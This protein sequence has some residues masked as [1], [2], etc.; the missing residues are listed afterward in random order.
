L[1]ALTLAALSCLALDACGGGSSSGDSAASN[2]A[3]P[4]G[5]SGSSGGTGSPGGGGTTPVSNG[6]LALATNTYTVAETTGTVSVTV[7]RSGGSDGAVTVQYATADGT[8]AAGSNYTAGTGT[9]SWAASD[10]SAKTVSIPVSSNPAFSGTKTFT[11]TLSSVAGGAALGTPMAA[12]VSI[13]GSGATS[14]STTLSIKVQGKHL[15]DGNG[16]TVQL[17]GAD[18]SGLETVAIQGWSHSDPWGGQ[19][20]NLQALKTWKLNAVRFPLNEASWLGLTTYDWPT[21]AE[22]AG[23]PRNADPGG[24]YKQTV[25]NSVNAAVAAGF[26]VILDLHLS[27]PNAS[28]PGISGKVPTSPQQQNPMADADHSPAFW[29]SVANTFKDNPAVIFDLFNEPHIDNFTGVTGA[30]EDPT[31]WMALRDGGTCTQ[32]LAG[33]SNEGTFIVT[34][35]SYQTAGM[36]SLVNAVRATGSTNVIMAAGVSWAQGTALWPTYAPTDP[37]NQLAASW[38]AYPQGFSGPAAGL[39][40]F[41]ADNYTWAL[42]IL[43]AGYPIIIGE[44]GDHSVPG[45]VGA[46]F[47]ANL[48]PWVDQ[49]G[50]ST[51]GWTWNAWGAADDDLI[52]DTAGTP[53]DGYGQA[54]HTWTVNHQ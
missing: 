17:R 41:G 27:A 35:Q 1:R 48:L 8:A 54:Y 45:T 29:T 34:T 46:P 30:L 12:T 44:T 50:V 25:I 7:N 21:G 47:M 20:P 14:S 32:W 38:H 16:T 43:A 52:K 31:A 11:L 26:Y 13:N 24:N 33:T 40:G 10:A 39:P 9:L 2:P 23:T 51:L 3:A 5:G 6:T 28:V 53:S 37:A 19:S 18:V 42:A 4:T 49:Q 15:I 36:Q 22:T